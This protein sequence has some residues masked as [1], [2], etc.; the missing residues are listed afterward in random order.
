MAE[1]VH[2]ASYPM[3]T[4]AKLRFVKKKL[5][6]LPQCPS[7]ISVIQPQ[8]RGS[9]CAHDRQ[10]K[11]EKGAEGKKASKMKKSKRKKRRK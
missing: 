5:R 4:C 11:D 7:P 6:Q 2:R 3:Q 10:A 1:A 9:P 8:R